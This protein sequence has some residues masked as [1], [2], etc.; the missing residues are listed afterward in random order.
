MSEIIKKE[1]GPLSEERIYVLRKQ[2]KERRYCIDEERGIIFLASKE[3]IK[4]YNYRLIQDYPLDEWTA[5]AENE[6][7]KWSFSKLYEDLTSLNF[8]AENDIE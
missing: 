1:D 5:G 3:D 2:M 7:E 6:Y 8:S 4:K